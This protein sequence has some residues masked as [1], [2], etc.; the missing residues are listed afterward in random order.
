MVRI[1]LIISVLFSLI[2]FN[3]CTIKEAYLL[4]A[5]VDA[6]VSQLPIHLSDSSQ[7]SPVTLSLKVSANTTNHVSGNISKNETN[8]YTEEY[9]SG[10][11]FDWNISQF[12][13]ATDADIR[14]GKRAA[15]FGGF[16]L[17]TSSN[18]TLWGG[19]VG[20]GIFSAASPISVRFDIGL[21]FQSTQVDASYYFS[22][23]TI[24]FDIP[25]EMIVN[26]SEKKLYT[27]PF[28]T[29][30]IYSTN[31]ESYIKPFLQLGY[32]NQ[33]L[34]NIDFNDRLFVTNENDLEI[35][36]K[37]DLISTSP[38]ISIDL[39]SNQSLLL[40]LRYIYLSSR[41]VDNKNM[42]LPFLQVD[43]KL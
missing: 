31:E 40:G 24:P 20:L 35:V 8:S 30:T 21:K 6:P 41:D 37:V 39:G 34:F 26:T 27:S 4:H 22:G 10:K 17:A 5:D 2:A 9:Y 14:L 11:N 15:F 12:S 42:L 38:G 33:T 19:N 28:A 1:V 13:F 7:S 3:A 18:S 29:F 16:D 25:F 36:G 32:A 43:F 23:E